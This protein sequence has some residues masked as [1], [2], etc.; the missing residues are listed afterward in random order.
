MRIESFRPLLSSVDQLQRTSENSQQ[1]GALQQAVTE[2]RSL[3]EG[4]PGQS[5]LTYSLEQLQQLL[6]SGAG[7]AGAG[8][9]GTPPIGTEKPHAIPP[10]PAGSASTG[11]SFGEQVNTAINH[12]NQLQK[13]ADELV[14]QAASGNPEDAHKAVIAMEHA[15][16]ALDFTLQVR[17]KVLDAYQEIMKT[18]L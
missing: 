2:L 18:Q 17:N 9:A 16:M 5:P 14:V 13:N 15:L 12:V 6:P 8:I 3:T 10:A 4:N 7:T 11:P 1:P